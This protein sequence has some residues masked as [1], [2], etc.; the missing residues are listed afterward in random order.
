MANQR[1]ETVAVNH[2]FA[3]VAQ[4]PA[5]QA[6]SRRLE[7]REARRTA[8]A[9]PVTVVGVEDQAIPAIR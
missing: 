6:L 1:L 8:T 3:T 2:L 4:T 9:G 5:V 7:V